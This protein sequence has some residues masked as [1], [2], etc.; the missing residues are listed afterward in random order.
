MRMGVFIQNVIGLK[1]LIGFDKLLTRLFSPERTD[2]S[3]F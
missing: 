1:E 2:I 3:F